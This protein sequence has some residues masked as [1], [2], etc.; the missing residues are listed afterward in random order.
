MNVF[1]RLRI[2]KDGEIEGLDLHEHG[3][4]AYPELIGASRGFVMPDEKEAIA[5]VHAAVSAA[6]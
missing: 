6:E 1:K 3:G 5:P 2:T 4:S